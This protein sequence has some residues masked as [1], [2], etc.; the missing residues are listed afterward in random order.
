MASHIKRGNHYQI[1]VCAGSEKVYG[2][3]GR[4]RDKKKRETTTFYP[5]PSWTDAQTERE[6]A[7]FE[8]DFERLVKS[9]K[10][11][12]GDKMT[13]ADLVERWREDYAKTEIDKT[14]WAKIENT[15]KKAIPRLGHINLTDLHRRHIKDFLRNLQKEGYERNGKHAEYADSSLD[16]HYRALSSIFGF[17][18][19]DLILRRE[20]ALH[21]APHIA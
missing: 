4:L 2:A 8:A 12:D 6:L 14:T 17:A 18:V 3:D 9:G 13:F 15:L 5:D 1:I 11:L 10:R 16:G 7:Y 19:S 20:K 21:N